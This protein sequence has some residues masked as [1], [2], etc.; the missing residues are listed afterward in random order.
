MGPRTPGGIW[1]GSGATLTECVV[2]AVLTV[3]CTTV[4]IFFSLT[5]SPQAPAP[6]R[7]LAA[8]RVRPTLVVAFLVRSVAAFGRY[9]SPP[10]GSRMLAFDF[11]NRDNGAIRAFAACKV[12]CRIPN[13]RPRAALARW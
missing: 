6:P 11:A 5:L 9:A 2:P 1:T 7:Q 10:N 12:E 3:T 4:G 8:R 13:L